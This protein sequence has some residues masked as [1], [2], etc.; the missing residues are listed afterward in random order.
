MPLRVERPGK[1]EK[2][3]RASLTELEACGLPQ[4]V[5]ETKRREREGSSCGVM[6]RASQPKKGASKLSASRNWHEPQPL[7]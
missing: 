3:F 7:A 2:E 4:I 1:I 5:N 6:L